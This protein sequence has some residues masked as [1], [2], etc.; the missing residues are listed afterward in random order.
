MESLGGVD[1][2]LAAE[3]MMVV[4]VPTLKKINVK[5]KMTDERLPGV[6]CLKPP[7]LL[8]FA[9]LRYTALLRLTIHL[10]NE[11]L[12]NGALDE[13]PESP[14]GNVCPKVSLLPHSPK[15]TPSDSEKECPSS[16]PLS[17]QEGEFC[18]YK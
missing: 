15:R 14:S 7:T 3:M 10:F 13:H 6:S 11:N 17:V 4:V 1:C 12:L 2:V 8:L 16:L 9:I 5:T 18:L